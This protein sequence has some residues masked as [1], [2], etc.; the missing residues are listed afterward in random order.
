MSNQGIP[1]TSFS[2][3]GAKGF[4]NQFRWQR[5]RAYF[6]DDAHCLRCAD[7]ETRME[8]PEL[9][10]PPIPAYA[11]SSPPSKIETPILIIS[12]PSDQL[13]VPSSP[14]LPSSPPLLELPLPPIPAY[15]PPLPPI[16]AENPV[17]RQQSSIKRKRSLPPQKPV[18][19]FPPPPLP[20]WAYDTPTVL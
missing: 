18:P 14:A 8:P 9:P 11:P 12:K 16:K 5:L 1:R 4:W 19:N 3:K 13:Y 10:L 7:L 6:L 2:T 17:L 20:A 15:P